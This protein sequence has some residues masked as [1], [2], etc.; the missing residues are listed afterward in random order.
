MPNPL[1]IDRALV[2]HLAELARLSVSAER[3]QVL[4]G[5]LER[6]LE[7]FAALQGA[8]LPTADRI[9]SAMA[10]ALRP[11]VA[12]APLPVET[13]LANAPQQAAGTF[14]V[15]RVVDA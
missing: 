4:R 11:D 7:A 15:P 6:V 12:E 1:V 9:E 13:V 3:A 2:Q 14:V 10:Q 8:E 5:R